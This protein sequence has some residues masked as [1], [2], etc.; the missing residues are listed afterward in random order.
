MKKLTW[1]EIRKEY[2]GQ[3]V[4]LIDYD[5]EEGTPYPSAGVVHLHA[6]TR[7][8]FDQLMI[9][10]DPIPGARLYVGDIKETANVIR[11]GCIRVIPNAAH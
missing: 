7:K 8:A 2:D 10:N 3:W 1:D 9:S 4:H 6:D 11:M 5:W